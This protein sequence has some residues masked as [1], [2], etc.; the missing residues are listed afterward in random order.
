MLKNFP[1]AVMAK[2]LCSKIHELVLNPS[3]STPLRMI[4]TIESD[5]SGERSVA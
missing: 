4:L 3:N 5:L 2:T 1:D